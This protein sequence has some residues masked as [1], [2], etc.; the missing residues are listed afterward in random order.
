MSSV[1]LGGVYV[2]DYNCELI[3]FW[4]AHVMSVNFT[5]GF[6]RGCAT[7]LRLQEKCFPTPLTQRV[8]SVTL[9][10][11]RRRLSSAPSDQHSPRPQH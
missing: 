1:F 9:N 6:L 7:V 3:H 8:R 5:E 10:P 11:T 4:K 2:P